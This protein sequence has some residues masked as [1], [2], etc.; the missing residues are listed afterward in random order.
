MSYFVTGATGFIGRHL[1]RRLL[2]ERTGEVFVLVRAGSRDRLDALVRGWGSDRVVPVVG[3]LTE[4]G[5]GVDDAWVTA[6]AGGIEHFFHVAAVYDMTADDATNQTMNVDGTRHALDLAEALRAGCFHQ[7]SSVAVA[8][9]YAGRF[10]ETMFDEGQ[11]LPSPYHRTKHESEKLVRY[12]SAVPWRVYRPAIVVGDSRTGAMDKVD[13]P[14]Y[15]FPLMKLMRD[16]LPAWLPLVGVDLGDTNVVPVDYVVQAMDHL[17]HLP[18]RD[19]ETFHLVDPDPQPVVDLVNAFCA[20]AGA[21]RFATPVDRSVTR[22]LPRVLQPAGLL[23][24]IAKVGPVQ[25]ALDLL[26][27]QV[28]IP[29]EVLAHTAFV[30]AFEATRTL[31]ALSGSGIALPVLDSYARTLWTWWEEH[32][33]TSTADDPATCAALAGKHVVI[34]GA[35]SGIGQVTALKVAQAGGI[36]V[37]VARG[38]DKLEDTRALIERAGGTAYV[39]PC[40]LSD[41]EAIDALCE[42]LAA[43]LPS[44][45]VVVNNAGRSI[46]RS[47]RLSHD[48]FHDFERTMQL[49]YFGAIRLVMGLLPLMR[50]QGRGHVVN[51]SS[52]GVQTNP[53][54]F[55]AYVASKAA[56]DSWS[57]VV[58]SELVGDGVTFTGIHMPLVRTPMIAPTKLYD[59]FPTISPAQAAD[60]VVRAMVERPHEINTLLGNAGAVVHTVAPKLAFRVLNMAYH[61]FPDSAAAKGESSGGRESEQIM[62]ARV[63]KGVHW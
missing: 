44:V 15:F 24:A 8:G 27:R 6:H 48:R 52:I 47:L 57:N 32:L 2:D 22:L 40:D 63:L 7:V 20:A 53:P 1:V 12:S 41:L 39:F 23:N 51:V 9:E 14:Y 26:T 37:L 11:T 58:A 42:Q 10:D 46:R 38:K 3:D 33:D 45:D 61:V 55:S 50:E 31:R 18:D 17:A 30:P 21:P 25:G 36:P 56:L 62:L 4:P 59:K 13:G 35:S 16:R 5:L 29:A 43:E 54:R 60:L 34:T 19:G 49:N 28:G